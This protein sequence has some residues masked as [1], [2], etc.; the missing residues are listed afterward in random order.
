MIEKIIY[1]EWF[2][3]TLFLIFLVP[4]AVSDIKKKRYPINSLSQVL[5]FLLQKG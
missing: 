4:I 1:S 2:D 5:P 3:F